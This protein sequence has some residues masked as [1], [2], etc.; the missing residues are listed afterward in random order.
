MKYKTGKNI[1]E[2]FNKKESLTNK[3]GGFIKDHKKGLAIALTL[4]ILEAGTLMYAYYDTKKDLEKAQPYIGAL[5]KVAEKDG[6]L[7][8]NYLKELE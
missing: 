3:V 4:A 5:E 1:Y 7:K 2:P 8:E 6:N